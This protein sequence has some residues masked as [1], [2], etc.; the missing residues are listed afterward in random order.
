M[1][2]L[3]ISN[4][5]SGLYHFRK[6]LIIKLLEKGHSIYISSPSGDYMQEF[7]EMGCIMYPTQIERHGTNPI[8]D[9]KLLWHYKRIIKEI[10]PGCALTYTIKPNIY[11]G[12]AC[13]KYKIPFV[14]NITGLGNSI[15]NKGLLQKIVLKLY[16]HSL[17]KSKRIFF[18]NESNKDFFIQ[19]K[20]VDER[21]I[22]TIPGSGVNLIEQAFEEYPVENKKIVFVTIGRV[23]KEKGIYELIDAA[24]SLKAKYDNIVFRVIG[25]IDG[26]C[27]KAIN[28]ATKTGIIEYLGR[29]EDIHDQIKV[30]HATIH[31]SY[32]E[33]TSNVLLETAACGRPILATN[34]P[35]CS[36][37]FIEGVSGFGFDVRSVDSLVSCVEKF[38]SLTHEER[39]KMGFEGRK[40]MELEFDRNIIIE[41]YLKVLEEINDNETL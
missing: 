12:I 30:S 36:N 26:N 25:E 20:L 37:T 24:K 23:M 5:D 33:G 8:K 29:R 1:K 41:E 18:Q 39:K 15:E 40:Y 19:H 3:I 31:P 22:K 34:V 6:E 14:V 38:L 21:K 10:K 13:G 2:I 32:H 17:K 27:Q 7:K 11:G 35:G 9:L 4:S 28:N 16:K